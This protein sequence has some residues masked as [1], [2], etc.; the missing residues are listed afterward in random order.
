V[1]SKAR[2]KRASRHHTNGESLTRAAF[3]VAIV[4]R[5]V[6]SIASAPSEFSREDHDITFVW[7]MRKDEFLGP[8]RAW[9]DAKPRI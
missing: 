8:L 7:A 1:S 5:E 4:Q 9:E 2:L 6:E 3:F